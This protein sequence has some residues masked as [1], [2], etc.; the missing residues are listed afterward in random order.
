M[1]HK[2]PQLQV[3]CGSFEYNYRNSLEALYSPALLSNNQ[4]A[5]SRIIR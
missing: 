2:Q 5:Q 4:M 1:N 3:I